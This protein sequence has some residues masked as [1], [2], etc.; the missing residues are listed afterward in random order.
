MIRLRPLVAGVA[1]MAALGS[2]AAAADTVKIAF[3]DP[4]SGLMAPVGQNQLKSW[5]YVAELA[6]QKNWAGGHKFEVVGFDNKL[7]PQESLTILKQAVDQGIRYVVQGNGSS[8][9]LALQDAVAKHNE[10]NPG[11]EIIYLNYAA[12]DPDMTNSKCNYW[13]FRLDANSDMKMEALTTY[14]AQDQNVKKVYLINQNYSFGHQV[15]RA[16]KEYL[17]RKRP[18]I[19]VVGE[20][21]HPLAQV[22][23]FSP[24]VAKIKAAGADTVITGNWGSDLALLIKAAKDAG[25][26]ANF[27]TYYAATT[28][29]PTAMGAAGAE[30]VRYV[31][32]YN[33]NNKG[34]RGSDVIEGYEKKYND[35]F[36][37]MASYTGIAMLSKAFQTAKSTDPVKVAKALE[38]MKVESMNGTVE[39]RATDHQAQQPL[40]IAT[41]TKV[42]GK[43]VKYDQENTGYGWKTNAVLDAHIAA[44]PTSC[45]MKRPG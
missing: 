22:K 17:K 31:G 39:M 32:Y 42:D 8:V 4:L 10:R 35:D 37:V 33:P 3:I 21:L 9:G 14:L 2:G 40:T 24:Y 12:V 29:V 41:W 20:D 13:H 36:Y 6:N 27:Y 38:G 19:Q 1:L 15:A 34:F 23:D 43:E 45:Q 7:S 11:K 26:T 16:A 30:R 44:Q 18:D 25:L 28:G 5:Q